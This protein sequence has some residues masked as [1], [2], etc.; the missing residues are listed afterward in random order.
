MISVA[1]ALTASGGEGETPSVL[2]VPLDEFI[3]GCVAFFIVFFALWKF[4]LPGIEKTLKE[5]S[6]AIEGG[7]E[8]VARAGDHLHAGAHRDAPLGA[9]PGGQ[10]Q[11]VALRAVL[12]EEVGG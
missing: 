8:R 9:P 7:I 11:L 10:R 3:L 4:V 1:T 2:A 12:V 6:D 5:R